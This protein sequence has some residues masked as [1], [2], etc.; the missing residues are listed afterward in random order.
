MEDLLFDEKIQSAAV[1]QQV[2]GMRKALVAAEDRAPHARVVAS[3]QRMPLEGMPRALEGYY[4]DLYDHGSVRRMDGVLRDMVTS[5]FE[6]NLSLQ[7]SRPDTIMKKL[8]GVGCDYRDPDRGDGLVCQ[9]V[10]PGYGR[11]AFGLTS[12]PR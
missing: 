5:V 4:T 1:Q 6:T 2:F 10:P 7:D 8:A 12:P 9:N 3:I 11:G